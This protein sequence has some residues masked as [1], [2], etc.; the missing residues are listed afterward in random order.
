[1]RTTIGRSFYTTALQPARKREISA[2]QVRQELGAFGRGSGLPHD[3]APVNRLTLTLGLTCGMI[4][5]QILDA[6][7]SRVGGMSIQ[8]QQQRRSFLDDPN[9]R[10]ARAVDPTLMPLGQGEPPLQVEVV[11][12]VVQVV[13]AGEEAGSEAAHHIDYML[14]ELIAV[15][16]QPSD[17][18]VE[19]GPASGR[20]PPG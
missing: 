19:V 17:D 11:W 18:R 10:M 3:L 16:V 5:P 13:P 14:M 1:L 15:T 9:P 8:G 12:D 6:E 4:R 20:F 7:R 2:F